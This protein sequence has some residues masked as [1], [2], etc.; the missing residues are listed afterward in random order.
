MG[1]LI[2]W[3][4]LNSVVNYISLVY[5]R[6]FYVEEREKAARKELEKSQVVEEVREA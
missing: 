5:T 1:V 2:G 6:Y 4:A 3:I